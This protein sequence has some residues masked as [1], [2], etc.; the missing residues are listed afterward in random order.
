MM[1]AMRI[2]LIALA[3]VAAH[4]VA[5]GNPLTP[6]HMGMGKFMVAGETIRLASRRK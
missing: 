1:A 6:H 3:C 4:A 5:S 2:P